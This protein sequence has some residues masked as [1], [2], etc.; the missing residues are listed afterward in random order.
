LT[1]PECGAFKTSAGFYGVLLATQ[2][3]AEVNMYLFAGT[4]E[5]YYNKTKSHASAS[6][7]FEDRHDWAAELTCMHSLAQL[8]NFRFHNEDTGEAPMLTPKQQRKKK[9]VR[10]PLPSTLL[11]RYYSR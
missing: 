8:P 2:L 6:L 11:R 4:Q 9:R 1:A 5:H 10:L 3:C 7:D